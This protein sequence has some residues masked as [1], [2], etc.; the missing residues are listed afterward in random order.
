MPGAVSRVARRCRPAGSNGRPRRDGFDVVVRFCEPESSSLKA[1]L[2]FRARVVTC[3][4][5]SYLARHGKPEE[6]KDLRNGHRCLLIRNQVTQR[7]YEW[8]FQRGPARHPRR[9]RRIPC[10]Q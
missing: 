7:P 5:P 10:G 4:S 1:R 2:L 9:R 8:E 3:A 6:P